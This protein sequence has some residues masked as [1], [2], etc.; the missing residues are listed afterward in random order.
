MNAAD[1]IKAID[2]AAASSPDYCSCGAAYN[3]HEYWEDRIYDYNG[4][5]CPRT[6]GG[7][8]RFDKPITDARRTEAKVAVLADLLSL[9]SQKEQEDTKAWARRL[10]ED[11]VVA[12]E[13]ETTG[14]TALEAVIKRALAAESAYAKATEEIKKLQELLNT[15]REASQP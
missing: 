14:Y 5:R 3:D 6:L 12:G 4:R 11:G 7:E 8:W 15:E 2:H 9:F 10:A 13:V 1:A